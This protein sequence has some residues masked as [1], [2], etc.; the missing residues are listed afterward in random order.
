MR[1]IIGAG[2]WAFFLG[3]AWPALGRGDDPRYAVSELQAAGSKSITGVDINDKGQVAGSVG[4]GDYGSGRAVLWER[5]KATF[6]VPP[7]TRGSAKR[8]NN[9]GQVLLDIFDDP[10]PKGG[11]E[12]PGSPSEPPAVR[13]HPVLWEKGKVTELGLK[14]AGDLSDDGAVLGHKDIGGIPH[15]VIWS[16]GE[17][18]DLTRRGI[19]PG[20]TTFVIAFDKRRVVGMSVVDEGRSSEGFLWDD[21]RVTALGRRVTPYAADGR[22]RIVGTV[23]E[24]NRFEAFL[25][26][27]GRLRQLGHLGHGTGSIAHAINGR[28]QVVGTSQ[29]SGV[30]LPRAFHWERGKMTDLNDLIPA[31][32]GWVLEEAYAIN[33]P[34]QIVGMGVR[35]EQRRGFLLDPH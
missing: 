15:A 31:S 3:V 17:L 25:W 19:K 33:E 34:G 23:G 22:G 12:P 24:T 30:A 6:L 35:G 16:H 32:S 20:Y 29:T 10:A 13:S 18:I 7:G 8:V 5:G 9:A 11:D 1:R 14:S 4:D 28:G 26:E 27:E 2:V 21:G